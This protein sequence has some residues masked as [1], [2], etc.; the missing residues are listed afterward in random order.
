M[1]VNHKQNALK[2]TAS[3]KLGTHWSRQ[4]SAY[5]KQLPSCLPQAK[6]VLRGG[7]SMCH[8]RLQDGCHMALRQSD[9]YLGQAPG[10]MIA[11]G[12]ESDHHFTPKLS[13]TRHCISVGL[14]ALQLRESSM[15][16]VANGYFTSTRLTQSSVTQCQRQLFSYTSATLITDRCTKGRQGLLS[17]LITQGFRGA[18][19]GI[20]LTCGSK[21]AHH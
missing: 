12:I 11:R 18:G 14:K 8:L 6:H 5:T 10:R 13:Q 16:K 21:V 3:I 2:L 19:P 1:K 4:V 17:K 15:I 20:Y 7:V 9:V